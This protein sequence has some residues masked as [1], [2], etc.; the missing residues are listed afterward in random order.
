[1]DI[2]DIFLAVCAGYC[3]Y[4]LGYWTGMR[5]GMEWAVDELEDS[6]K[7]LKQLGEK[8]YADSSREV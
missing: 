3:V 7:I 1:M 4:R 5:D 2:A 6:A 8:V